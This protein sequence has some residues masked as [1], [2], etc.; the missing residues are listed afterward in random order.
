[1]SALRDK[2]LASIAGQLGRPHGLLGR[3]VAR[4]L[5]RGNE[6]AIAAAVEATGAGPGAAVADIG[7]GGGIGLRLLLDRVGDTGTVH[8]VEIAEDMLRRAKSRFS[9]DMRSGRLLLHTG[10]MTALPLDDAS[11]DALITLNTVYFIDDLG[12]AF[13]ELARV[14]RPDGRVVV[15][16]GDP[17]AMRRAPFTRYGFTLRPVA[18]IAAAL[19]DTGMTVEHRAM[20]HK[21]IPGHLFV[22]RHRG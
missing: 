7:F 15:G 8:G 11:L 10:S 9:A 20:A 13:A 19:T 6:R 5:N 1:M 17:D 4:A 22:A 18:D 2:L 21:P 3:A 14:I 16:I 12:A